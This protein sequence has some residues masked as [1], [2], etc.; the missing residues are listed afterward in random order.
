MRKSW[1][2]AAVL[3]GTAGVTQAADVRIFG[4]HTQTSPTTGR[5]AVFAQVI[6]PASSV[7][8]TD[9]VA[10]LSSA[11]IDVLNNG[12]AVVQTSINT[13][14]KGTT[15]FNDNKFNPTNVGYG[16]WLVRSDG[17]LPS[18]TL[19]NNQPNPAF[20]TGIYGISGG[21]YTFPDSNGVPYTQLVIPGVGMS[22]GNTTVDANHTSTA[23]WGAPVQIATGSYTP[24]PT[25]SV[26]LKMQYTADTEVNLLRDADPGAG[27][28]WKRESAVSKTVVDARVFTGV[29][30]AGVGDTTIKAGPGDA[31]LDGVINFQDLVAVAQNYDGTNRTWF[32]GD[33]DGDGVVGFTDLV[34]IAQRYDQPVPSDPAFGSSFQA[35]VARAF[36]S[37]PEPGTIGL[38]GGLA[39]FGLGSRK[40]KNA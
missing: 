27:F 33:F 9:N 32:E 30:G 40:R 2:L 31:N 17:A 10:G 21:Q 16:F 29:A 38:L 15:P 13:L 37:V 20:N 28:D 25:T 8:P 5:W 39:L 22:R 7:V 14:P 3:G 12:G 35:D 36:A 26:G 24:G 4:I 23:S 34:T 6:N 19:P 11:S 18:A 1:L